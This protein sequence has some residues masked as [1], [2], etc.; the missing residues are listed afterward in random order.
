M[1][2]VTLSSP[3]SPPFD[4]S[5]A[6]LGSGLQRSIL[7]APA[8]VVASHRQMPDAEKCN[9]KQLGMFGGIVPWQSTKRDSTKKPSTS[10]SGMALVDPCSLLWH[11]PLYSATWFVPKAISYKQNSAR[12]PV[13]QILPIT[14]RPRKGTK[15]ARTGRCKEH[16]II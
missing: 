3:Q 14:I 13:P 9:T 10:A 15:L 7:L 11:V 2:C 12:Q 8:A 4:V 5:T 16:I 6:K 1:L